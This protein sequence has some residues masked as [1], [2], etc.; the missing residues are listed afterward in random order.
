MEGW[1]WARER[2]DEDGWR[3][4]GRMGARDP[5]L[6]PCLPIT[7]SIRVRAHTKTHTAQSASHSLSLSPG[8]LLCSHAPLARVSAPAGPLRVSLAKY[9][10]D[11]E[12]G[13][14]DGQN[15]YSLHGRAHTRLWYARCS[16]ITVFACVG[17]T[18]RGGVRVTSGSAAPRG[19]CIGPLCAPATAVG[20]CRGP[21][22]TAAAAGAHSDARAQAFVGRGTRHDR[23][24]LPQAAHGRARPSSV[25]RFACNPSWP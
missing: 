5:R 16:P 4:G 23:D 18:D 24:T 7:H 22:A 17:H 12:C 15:R 10:R 11:G 21:N 9:G 14:D 2:S 13:R 1:A 20:A 8:G 19:A 25:R 3:M 6:H